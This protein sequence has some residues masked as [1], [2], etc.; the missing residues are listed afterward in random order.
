MKQNWKIFFSEIDNR[1][2]KVAIGMQNE[3]TNNL[4][5]IADILVAMETVIAFLDLRITF[6]GPR[7]HYF[8]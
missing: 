3:A 5:L 4:P 7:S 1:T 6:K 8:R 2:L